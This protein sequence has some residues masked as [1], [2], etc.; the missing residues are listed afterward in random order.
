MNLTKLLLGITIPILLL[1][2]FIGTELQATDFQAPWWLVY[3]VPIVSVI[4]LILITDHFLWHHLTHYIN[5]RLK[6]FEEKLEQ[7]T[8]ECPVR[9]EQLLNTCT[10]N[11]E[12]NDKHDRF[13]RSYIA[14]NPNFILSLRKRVPD[15]TPTEELLCMY[16]DMGLNN[17][18]IAEQMSISPGS[19]H[20][21]RYRIKR[22]LPLSEGEQMDDW[23][24]KLNTEMK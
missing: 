17:K 5:T 22:K 6:T 7:H 23:I 9:K 16:V 11:I 4:L 13:R 18:E 1:F 14:R 21:F 12:P 15:I 10:Q 19:L 8:R 2:L 3:L 20:T 24:R